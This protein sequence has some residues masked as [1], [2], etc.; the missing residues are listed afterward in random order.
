M[1]SLETK[2]S[3]AE[4]Q[5]AVDTLPQGLGDAYEKTMERIRDQN[6]DCRELAER[7]LSWLSYAFRLLTVDELR[8]ALAVK[9]GTHYL[10]RDRLIP[11]KRLVSVCAGLVIIDRESNIIRLVHYT[12][13]E[14]FERIRMA[15]FPNAQATIATA[16]LTYM[17]FDVFDKGCCPSDK[18]LED[19]LE[20]YPLLKYA[21]QHWGRHIR[22]NLEETVKELVLEFLRHNLKLMCSVQ[23]MH[24]TKY[25]Y[26]KYT[27]NFPTD[28][29]GLQ[30][31]VF[32]G[33]RRITQLLVEKGA[34]IKRK[35]K[36]GRTMLHMAALR[37]YEEA[38]RLLLSRSDTEFNSKTQDGWTPLW[39][40]ALGKHEAVVMLLLEDK[41]VDVNSKDN[42]GRTLLLEAAE[43]G[44]EAIVKLLLT[45]PGTDVNAKENSH[46]RTPLW[47][48]AKGGHDSVVKLLVTR[49]DVEVNVEDTYD[50]RT[51]LW[52]AARGGHSFVVGL[53]LTHKGV[54]VN[55]KDIF[56][57]RTPLW[58]A[59]GE[60]HKAVVEL[61]LKHG[62]IEVNSKD[63]FDGRTPLWAAAGG[64]YEAVVRLLLAHRDIE[65]NSE[66][67]NGQTPLSVAAAR[68][69]EAVVKLLLMHRGMNSKDKGGQTPLLVAAGSRHEDVVIKV[70]SND[71]RS[72]TL[73]PAVAEGSH[74]RSFWRKISCFCSTFS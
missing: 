16:C 62:D 3:L 20:E 12:A 43:R 68:R 32:F 37:G 60:G 26:H 19:R 7:I 2:N 21:A 71:D 1:D 59:A 73:L 50:G 54:E 53:L 22:G 74:K 10:N 11:E 48:A 35:D 61:L 44:S 15:R 70:N 42:S 64:G 69:H 41:R 29:D 23:V 51:P 58:Q 40:A 31:A 66:D 46:G 39:E 52:V 34:D 18:E 33:L 67:K 72:Q 56:D 45:Q 4:L 36:V 5:K 63:R 24:L 9:S 49:D 17:S 14:Y 38:V 65:V 30:I 8:H 13:Q 55:S 47:V 28:I 57:D 6:Q 27:Q 25:R